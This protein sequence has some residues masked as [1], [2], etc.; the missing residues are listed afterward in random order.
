MA[1]DAK[2]MLSIRD[3]TMRFRMEE[4]HTTSLKETVMKMFSGTCA[5]RAFMRSAT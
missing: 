2:K 5:S 1:E 4:D 3:V